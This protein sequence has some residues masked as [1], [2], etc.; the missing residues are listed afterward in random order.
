MPVHDKEA[1]LRVEPCSV[2]EFYSVHEQSDP[3][4]PSVR[5]LPAPVY[6]RDMCIE[7][8]GLPSF[9]KRSDVVKLFSDADLNLSDVNVEGEKEGK[10]L[11]R[12]F[13][14]CRRREDFELLLS[15]NGRLI[16]QEPFRI[17][18]ISYCQ[19]CTLWKDRFRNEPRERE[20][21]RR[22]EN[23]EHSSRE[24]TRVRSPERSGRDKT[25]VRDS[26]R[27]ERDRSDH[28]NRDDHR[29]KRREERKSD[30]HKKDVDISRRIYKDEKP[31]DAKTSQPSLTRSTSHESKKDTSEKIVTDK[32][33]PKETSNKSFCFR[34]SNLPKCTTSDIAA[35][36][37]RDRLD[38][39]GIYLFKNEGYA[40][41]DNN[42]ADNNVSSQKSSQKFGNTIRT[43]SIDSSEL[44]SKMQEHRKKYPELHCHIDDSKS[45]SG[46][47]DEPENPPGKKIASK[48]DGSL[49]K[50]Q[51]SSNQAY[52]TVSNLPVNATVSKIEEFF[53]GFKFIPGSITLRLSAQGKPLGEAVVAFGSAAEVD[54]VIRNTN[55]KKMGGRY[56]TTRL[57]KS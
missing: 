20:P 1:I 42:S 6:Y 7:I 23:R 29:F 25:R 14:I 34:L 51:G 37:G 26:D 22:D 32:D 17:L 16:Y 21:G 50:D 10:C 4:P 13:I 18:A 56:I 39:R 41:V 44:K 38:T 43:Q 54:R 19:L 5:D 30:E 45:V 53:Q 24:R 33:H 12:A 55:G 11:G 9:Y 28:S 57:G 3:R 40:I 47:I 2:E 8:V 36:L 49:V 27:R 15:K 52:L 46:C 31:S 35:F 48:E